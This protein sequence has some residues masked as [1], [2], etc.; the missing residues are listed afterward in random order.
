MSIHI[1]SMVAIIGLIGVALI[2]IVAIQSYSI[3]QAVRLNSAAFDR[4]VYDALEKTVERIEAE[5]RTL[6]AD[7]MGINRFAKE[8]NRQ[9]IFGE[10]EIYMQLKADTAHRVFASKDTL[11][12]NAQSGYLDHFQYRYDECLREDAFERFVEYVM[13]IRNKDISL[14]QRP[15]MRY[16][17]RLLQDELTKRGLNIAYQ[18]AIFS[19]KEDRFLA[20]KKN[21]G[22]KG[23][24]SK[25]VALAKASLAPFIN[26]P[27]KIDL[28]PT[29]EK[30]NTGGHLVAYFP[31]KD[32]F[33]R[34]SG[35]LI[36]L[37][38]FVSIA[39]IMFCFIYVIQIVFQQKKLSEMKNDFLNNMTH[40]FKTPIATI[41][42]A[43]DSITNPSILANTEKIKRFANII[44][45]ENRRMNSQ[46]ERVLQMAQI[47]KKEFKLNIQE[48]NINELIE[49]AISA[50]CLQ[51]EK[52]D[53][54]IIQKLDCD[55][56]IIEA[57]ETHIS[58][59]IHNL[60][61]NA[62]KYSPETPHITVKTQNVSGGVQISV[63][64]KGIGISKDAR[65]Y[66]FDKFYRVPTGN[67]HDVKGFGLG[68]SYVKSIVTAHGGH[69]QVKSEL[70][71]GTTFIVFL[72]HAQKEMTIV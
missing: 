61:D 16:L 26:S 29:M 19:D 12:I 36:L 20:I 54:V 31:N 42:L 21:D 63:E 52:K 2:G 23:T 22:Q 58:N 65:K 28:F 70:G 72:P 56:P 33:V 62:N 32:G 11:I 60:M 14:D 37:G 41:S 71:K 55:N 57:D 13:D 18:Y 45:E 43:T 44:R 27:Y 46:V 7:E 8:F 34:S 64:D 30:S 47:D 59:V 39:V 24:I 35:W 6:V 48:T 1:K 49:I 4:K 5:E 69:I 10:E 9:H 3:I 38:S 17:D 15:G 68:L 51:V 50:F 66:I 40:E 25:D 53:G 67:V